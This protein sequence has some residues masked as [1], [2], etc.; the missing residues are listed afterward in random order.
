[1][2]ED[3]KKYLKAQKIFREWEIRNFGYSP[4]PLLYFGIGVVLIVIILFLR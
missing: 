3:L 2:E 4:K 1:M